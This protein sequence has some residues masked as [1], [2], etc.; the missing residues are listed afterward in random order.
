[1][2]LFLVN[3]R[4]KANSLPLR[5]ETRSDHLSWAAQYVDRIAMAG[6][7]FS[8]NGETMAGSTFVISFDS[9]SAAQDWALQDPYAQAGLFE[10]VEVVPFNWSIGDGK[11]SDD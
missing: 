4:D 9:L 10:T 8:D 3:A 6:P 11:P 5:L 2:P 7:V 1:M